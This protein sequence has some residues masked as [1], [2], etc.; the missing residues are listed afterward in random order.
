MAEK[1]IT[2]PSK[3][4]PNKN[5]LFTAAAYARLSQEEFVTVD[6]SR[7]L[8]RHSLGAT[9]KINAK[10]L[11]NLEKSTTP[12]GFAKQS[13][14]SR[15]SGIAM[16]V[17]ETDSWPTSWRDD[18]ADISQKTI[19]PLFS[20]K[21]LTVQE[22]IGNVQGFLT[23]EGYVYANAGPQLATGPKV[24]AGAYPKNLEIVAKDKET[25][26]I[27]YSKAYLASLGAQLTPSSDKVARL[28]LAADVMAAPFLHPWMQGTTFT[29]PEDKV[30]YDDKSNLYKVS[31][32]FSK[33]VFIDQITATPDATLTT[34]YL[35][36]SPL[37][38][39]PPPAPAQ[40]ALLTNLEL[41]VYDGLES[42][43]WLSSLGTIM[44]M[45]IAANSKVSIGWAGK[46]DLNCAFSD[47]KVG[48][49]S[50]QL[51]NK[52]ALMEHSEEYKSATSE[53]AIRNFYKDVLWPDKNISL[54]K[55][56]SILYAPGTYGQK[57][58]IVLEVDDL[59]NA[60]DVK[61]Q[62]YIDV[63]LTAN[64]K[65]EAG[66][67]V[68]KLTDFANNKMINKRVFLRRYLQRKLQ[69]PGFRLEYKN[70]FG[71]SEVLYKR[72]QEDVAYQKMEVLK[73]IKKDYFPK[74][75][76]F[77]YS[78]AA[79]VDLENLQDPAKISDG[80]LLVDGE[81]NRRD[82]TA[83]F[84]GLFAP[85]EVVGYKISKF[86]N[87]NFA[88]N[89]LLSEIIILGTT[90]SS[91]KIM[92]LSYKDTQILLNK[93]YDYKV[94]E[95]VLVY[96]NS[97]SYEMK[98]DKAI[99]T[100]KG[101]PADNG[102][103]VTFPSNSKNFP[104]YQNGSEQG[105]W[106]GKSYSSK[107]LAGIHPLPAKAYE[108]TI[109]A[110]EGALTELFC[111]PVKKKVPPLTLG[112]V[113][114]IPGS[115]VATTVTPPTRPVLNV[116]TYE[117]INNKVIIGFEQLSGGYKTITTKKIKKTYNGESFEDKKE[118][119]EYTPKAAVEY[120][121]LFRVTEQPLSYDDFPVNPHE[122][123]NSASSHL[124]DAIEP[125]TKYWYYAKGVTKEG[126]GGDN[127]YIITVEIIDEHGMIYGIIDTHYLE[128]E[129][130]LMKR[131]ATNKN[132]LSV[133]S[134][135]HQPFYKMRPTLLGIMITWATLETAKVSME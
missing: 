66:A 74:N 119:I 11:G 42:N 54:Q 30:L 14:F 129:V 76:L 106:D 12:V 10:G 118:T 117:E 132:V 133:C 113:S 67:N 91:G 37:N 105:K 16:A 64:F 20:D 121:E 68:T 48:L 41:P 112:D 85:Y 24:F 19:Y 21:K 1:T 5:F 47:E 130:E 22:A 101:L 131:H 55:P 80:S 128:G 135:S 2:I 111:V 4:I 7:E 50:L 99:Y 96:G 57:R 31:V 116:R 109:G 84:H 123:V 61:D 93:K 89:T 58:T 44:R 18:K 110:K 27:R 126:V 51:K 25:P 92:S 71:E 34:Q 82:T 13:G 114:E 23:K 49:Q 103:G 108:Y 17:Q 83:I 62:A 122:I 78:N 124:I 33:A 69:T 46:D 127:S 35:Q 45:K 15:Y 28:S 102:K 43:T 32:S 26:V 56:D 38:P 36:I 70:D 59:L 86:T 94:E 60:G 73:P 65:K 6:S 79:Y 100:K 63:V 75:N 134:A 52:T 90:T 88:D 98:T 87:S 9:F 81:F 107:G 115:T 97:L 104:M 40:Q 95:L 29:T 3:D 53:F 8:L 125:N 72:N 39:F 120:Y 77:S